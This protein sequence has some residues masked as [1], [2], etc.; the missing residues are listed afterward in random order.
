MLVVQVE[1]MYALGVVVTLC[2]QG[3]RL[4]GIPR[5]GLLGSHC[6]EPRYVGRCGAFLLGDRFVELG[7]VCSATSFVV[8]VVG[9]F[10]L[11]RE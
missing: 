7:V 3:Q 6:G 9:I 10:G 11:Y 8:D 2:S 4:D 5:Q 1:V